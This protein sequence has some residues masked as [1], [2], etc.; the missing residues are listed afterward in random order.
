MLGFLRTVGLGGTPL[1][2]LFLSAVFSPKPQNHSHHQKPDLSVSAIFGS[3]EPQA[4][5][6]HHSQQVLELELQAKKE[7]VEGRGQRD[8]LNL[9]WKTMRALPGFMYVSVCLCFG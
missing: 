4:G 8:I 7:R 6:R 1:V 5:R 3:C 9:K 2:S